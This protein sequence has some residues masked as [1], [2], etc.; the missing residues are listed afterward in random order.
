MVYPILLLQNWKPISI[1]IPEF[2]SKPKSVVVG[3]IDKDERL[4]L[5]HSF[6]KSK[7]KKEG[8]YCL[9]YK[10]KPINSDWQWKKISGPQGIKYEKIE[11][12]DLDGD[13]DL[14]VLTCEEN[15]GKNSIGLGVIWF[16]N[17]LFSN[18]KHHN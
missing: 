9:S 14:D 4:D 17:Q 15:Y 3:D 10:N 1:K 18:L 7:G 13:G 2:T 16:K 11:L 12:V 5:V 6:E 8:V